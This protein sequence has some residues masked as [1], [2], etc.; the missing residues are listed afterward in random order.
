MLIILVV[1]HQLGWNDKLA[2]STRGQSCAQQAQLDVNAYQAML[3]SPG[4]VVL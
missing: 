3:M 1:T 2:L 4:V